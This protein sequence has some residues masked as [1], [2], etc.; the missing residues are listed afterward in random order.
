[1]VSKTQ[2]LDMMSKQY[3]QLEK[4]LD[5]MLSRIVKETE[6]IKDLEEQLTEGRCQEF[7]VFSQ[8]GGEGCVGE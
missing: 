7:D 6:S 3:K 2:Q 5:E 8:D 4:H 1:M